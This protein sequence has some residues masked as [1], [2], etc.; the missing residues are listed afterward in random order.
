MDFLWWY[1]LLGF[2]AILIFGE[3]EK[4]L[5]PQRNALRNFISLLAAFGGYVFCTILFGARLSKVLPILQ[6]VG[7]SMIYNS[8][9]LQKKQLKYLGAL[10]VSGSWVA[11]LLEITFIIGT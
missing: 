1:A 6:F 9:A 4:I 7:L 3:L 10:L 11:L 5:S 8:N 2:Y